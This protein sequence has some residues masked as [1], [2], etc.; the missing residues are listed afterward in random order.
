MLKLTLGLRSVV[1]LLLLLIPETRLIS[2]QDFPIVG[3]FVSR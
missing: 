1:R 2:H 3:I